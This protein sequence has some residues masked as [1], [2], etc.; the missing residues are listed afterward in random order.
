[1]NYLQL[2]HEA[3]IYREAYIAVLSGLLQTTVAH[4]HSIELF[5]NKNSVSG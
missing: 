2:A 5:L 1:M 3:Q 4:Y